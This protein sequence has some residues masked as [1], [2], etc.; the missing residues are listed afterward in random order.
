MKRKKSL[1]RVVAF[2]L[3]LLLFWGISGIEGISTFHEV[4]AE[5]S[6]GEMAFSGYKK[7]GDTIQ[8]INGPEGATY[9]WKVVNQVTGKTSVTTNTTGK[10]TT[11]EAHD[12]CMIICTVGE[13]E[14]SMYCSSLPVMYI[15]SEDEY[16]EVQKE[17]YSDATI[18]LIGN[19]LYDEENM[20][21]E[22]AAEIKLRGNSTAYR[23][24]RPFRVKLDSK[25]NLLG[26]GTEDN[27]KSYKSKHWVLLANDIDH[28]LIRNKLL[29]DFSGAIGTEFY[30][31]ST[32]VEVVYNGEYVGT[33]LLC[34]HRRVDEGRI[35]ITD[36]VGIGEDAAADIAE[37]EWETA[38][39]EDAGD[40]EDALNEVMYENYS[41]MNNGRVKLNG[42]TYRFENYG[43]ELPDATGG[44]L[45]EMDFYSIGSNT[46]A[47]LTTAYNQ[48]LYFSHPEA[49]SDANDVVAG[50]DSFKKTELYDY[51]LR[52]T[53]A[54]EYALHSKNFLFKNGTHKQLS[55]GGSY[56]DA[57]G[58]TNTLHDVKYSDD[59]NNEKHYSELFDMDSLVTNFI[60]VEYAM[61]WDSMKNSFFYYKDIDELA[62]IGPQWDFDWC[63]GN[64]NMFNIYTNVPTEWHTT[65]E[66]FTREQ[67]YQSANWNRLL[68]KDPYF[69]VR[70]Y[71]KYQEVRPI[72]EEMIEDGG[73]I[74]QYAEYLENAGK[75]NDARWDYTYS[76]EYGGA[77][78]EDFETS[79]ESLKTF[80]NT[81]VKWLDRQFASL[82]TLIDSLGYYEEAKEI[83]VQV[84]GNVAE[85]VTIDSACDTIV[86]QV[87]GTYLEEVDVV[88][89]VATFVIPKDNL[90][91]DGETM[92]VV[93]AYEKDGDE[94]I[95]NETL[96][97][98]GNYEYIAKS[99]FDTFA[100]EESEYPE[101]IPGD[102]NGDK[103]VDTTDAQAIFNH[104]M[105]IAPI[106]N[107]GLL[108]LAD[109]NLDNSVDTSDAQMAFNMFMGII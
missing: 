23:P 81:R 18:R 63:W 61:N 65:V 58:W 55:T 6:L 66:F 38:G 69:L 9:K 12:E 54:F 47:A 15:D 67:P 57:T 26:L 21:Y 10:F 76:T 7:L 64:I 33:Y 72:I 24:K 104:F 103:R 41:W 91:L 5:N 89:G 2:V 42:V 59:E 31:H 74:D 4:K 83:E 97:P 50:V 80:V 52:Y 49:G 105:G 75:A 82:E 85:A 22:G 25:A 68:I 107:A 39:Y 94:Y 37:E 62:K 102:V 32:N 8:V 96:K 48:P 108:K 88:D 87:N 93:V 98:S 46:L 78:A 99:A 27:G 60:F 11:K 90:I 40:M 16:Y 92:N 30:F 56:S 19:A 101:G 86:F 70:V 44:Y 17:D 53:Q 43:I 20:L 109:V 106:E 13:E 28:T 36:W 84:D 79:M 29:Y 95:L 14:L 100:C 1:K 73:T 3:W 35:D 34:E 51:A 71:E 77:T 45:A